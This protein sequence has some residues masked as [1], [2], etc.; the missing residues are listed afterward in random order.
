MIGI[1]GGTF[2]PIHFGH[3]RPALEVCQ[4]FALSEVRFIPCGEPPHRE[5]PVANAQ[6]RL[7]MVH[8][9]IQGQSKF[10]VD[11]REVQRSGPSY[12]VDTLGSLREELGDVPLCL[13]IG[14]DV[15]LALDKWHDWYLIPELAHIIVTHR[16]GWSMTAFQGSQVLQQ[17]VAQRQVATPGALMERPSGWLMFQPVTQL[18]ISSSQIR[19]A[20]A[21][22][23]SVRYLLPD[24]VCEYIKTENL[25]R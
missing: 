14:M 10:K 25:Y 11:D 17:F 3:L 15:F 13:I 4:A 24:S 19:D 21:G 12:M 5:A 23:E 20:L 18:A 1:F 2:D 8:A 6:Q 7:A 22:R 16:P 9:A